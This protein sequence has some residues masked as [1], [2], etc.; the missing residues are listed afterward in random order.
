[1]FDRVVDAKRMKTRDSKETVGVFL[2]MISEKNRSKKICRRNKDL[3]YNEWDQAA[4]AER[5]IWSLK[6]KLYRYMEDDGYKYIH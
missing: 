3:L 5:T 4:F 6:K 2:T 1:M